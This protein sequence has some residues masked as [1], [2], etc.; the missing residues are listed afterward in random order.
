MKHI[1]SYNNYELVNLG[2]KY[3]SAAIS[4]SGNKVVYDYSKLLDIVYAEFKDYD[5]A[6]EY[7]DVNLDT[8]KAIIYD[9]F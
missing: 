1:I 7:I 4:I 6:K 5:A 8:D 3:S 2:K 9:N